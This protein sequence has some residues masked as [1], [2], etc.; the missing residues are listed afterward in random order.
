MET[1][2]TRQ[3]LQEGGREKRS[4]ENTDHHKILRGEASRRKQRRNSEKAK[5]RIGISGG[6]HLHH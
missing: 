3:N 4:K 1:G 5:R 6:D 2:K